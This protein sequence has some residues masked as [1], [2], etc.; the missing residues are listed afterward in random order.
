VM[1]TR[2]LA[3]AA[4]MAVLAYPG[5]AEADGIYIGAFGGANFVEDVDFELE[6]P[7]LG[8][9]DFEFEDETG[10]AAGGAVGYAFDFGLRAEVEAAYRHNDHD[11][12]AVADVAFE[13]DGETLPEFDLDGE[14]TALSFMGNLWFDVPVPFPVRPFIGAGAGMARVGLEDTEAAG[15]EIADDSEWVFAYQLGAGLGYE[16]RPGLSVGAEYRFFETEDPELEVFGL[17]ADYEYRSHSVLIGVR[18]GIN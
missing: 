10:W 14:T 15:V 13:I 5:R 2:L 1:R 12:G 4:L 11:E 18:Y 16:I 7:V 9:V 3:T 6:D 17:D 8:P